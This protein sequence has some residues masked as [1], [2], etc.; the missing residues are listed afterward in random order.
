MKSSLNLRSQLT[1]AFLACGLLPLVVMSTI[2]YFRAESGFATV[3]QHANEV[4]EQNATNSLIA[5]R[6][7]K[8]KQLKD[9]FGTIDSQIKTFSENQMVVDAMRD[10]GQ[11]FQ[12]FNTANQLT[13]EQ[14]AEM[15][16][17][18]SGYY[19]ETFAPEYARRNDNRTPDAMNYLKQLDDTT[20]ALQHAYILENENPLGEKHR[21]EAAA[22]NSKYTQLHKKLHP[23][24]R[25]YLEEFGYYDIFLVDPD[26]GKI[27]YSVFKELDFGTSLK[28]GPYANSNFADAFRQAAQVTE[29]DSTVLV[30]F[31]RYTP[32]YEAPASFIASPIYD[33]DKRIGIAMFQMPVD[34]ILNILAVRDGM[35]ETGETIL[36]GPDYLMR[37]NSHLDPEGHSLLA[38]WKY[39]EKGK[40]DIDVTR[41]VFEKGETGTLRA[42]DYR[43]N[44]SLNAYCPIELNGLTYCLVAKMDASEAFA[45]SDKMAGTVENVKG[46]L[47]TWSMGIGLASAAAL[48]IFA[49]VLSRKIASPIQDAAQFAQRIAAGDLRTRCETE[50]TAEVGY[51]IQ[52]M[53]TM[54]DNLS[55]LLGEVI[56][57][58]DI[59]QGSSTELTGTAE[60]LSQGAYETT[61]RAATV[62][63][64]A[65][66]MSTN[67]NGMA[68]ATEQMSTNIGSVATA[69]EEMSTTI[70]EI[71]RNAERA[72]ASVSSVS[73]LSETSNERIASLGTAAAE[74]GAV[75]QTIQEIAEQTNLLALN[76][77]IE[78]ARAGEAGKGFS[79]VATEVKELARQTATATEDIRKRV[80]AIQTS[81]YDAVESIARI[82][83]EIKDVNEIAHTIASSVE[84]Q[85][86][87]AKE[88]AGNVAQAATAARTVSTGIHESATASHEISKNISQVNNSANESKTHAE[89]TKAAGNSLHVRADGLQ[90]TLSRFQLSGGPGQEPTLSA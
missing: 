90:S 32:S 55:G 76:A 43:E 36:V 59:L 31:A 5:Q 1:I 73:N 26:S 56:S 44:D 23:V 67:M 64:A 79:V 49:F 84:E 81:S 86:I 8:K 42:A 48:A 3:N 6:E 66:Q 63:A 17:D 34:R 40:V 71:A 69:M 24:V 15:R 50:A 33:G 9:Y 2:S 75:I 88:I 10:M 77:T 21:L 20:V 53:N 22:D 12:E 11:A 41:A 29:K 70:N 51:L 25:N 18:L 72:A 46:S 65:D 57:T 38:S 30:D 68:A 78:A 14:V 82:T 83:T 54:R 4:F 13:D 62:A 47:L 45:A 85:G 35:G 80:D 7:L 61:E 87:T 74:I 28:N 58:S 37:S 39:P 16:T 19:A 52:A 60:H 89:K 27:I